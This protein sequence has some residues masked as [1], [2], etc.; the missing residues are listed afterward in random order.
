[1]SVATLTLYACAILFI[2]ICIGTAMGAL[3][4]AR[5]DRQ[6]AQTQGITAFA[7]FLLGGVMLL[8]AHF[9]G[10][11]ADAAIAAATKQGAPKPA[12]AN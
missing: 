9:I 2:V 8:A 1:M 12:P 11:K 4:N 7:F 3:S 6:K 10:G 5:K